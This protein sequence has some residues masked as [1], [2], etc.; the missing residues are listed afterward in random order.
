LYAVYD[1]PGWTAKT[2]SECGTLVSFR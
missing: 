1:E 2:A